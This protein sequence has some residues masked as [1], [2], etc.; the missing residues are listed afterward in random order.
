MTRA[1][2]VVLGTV[3][4]L[5]SIL[6]HTHLQDL[7]VLQRVNWTFRRTIDTSPQL[8]LIVQWR[9]GTP[10]HESGGIEFNLGLQGRTL[11]LNQ[12]RTAR[13]HLGRLSGPRYYV[14][15][16]INTLHAGSSARMRGKRDDIRLHRVQADAAGE[17]SQSNVA[18]T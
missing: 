8:N 11:W 15:A 16:R 13:L 3:E 2:Q 14:S 5:E 9:D 4:L 18:C 7:F 12:D 17:R 1:A 10:G 6:S